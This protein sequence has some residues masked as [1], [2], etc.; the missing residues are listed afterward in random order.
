[1]RESERERERL[2]ESGH[3]YPGGLVDM[4][5]ERVVIFIQADWL[6]WAEWEACSRLSPPNVVL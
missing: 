3:S 2:N 6:I 5:R 1:M 4:G